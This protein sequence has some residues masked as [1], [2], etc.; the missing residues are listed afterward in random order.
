MTAPKLLPILAAVTVTLGGCSLLQ[1]E[2]PAERNAALRLE[3][4]LAALEAGAYREAFDELAWVYTHCP[5]RRAGVHALAALA[6]LELD[7]RNRA[8]RPEIGSELLA[9]VIRDPGTPT[10][11]RPLAESGYLMAAALG[12]PPA[13]G[14][15]SGDGT[16]RNSGG[17]PEAG[18]DQNGT[19]AGHSA[20]TRDRR[21]AQQVVGHRVTEPAY[22]CGPSVEAESWVPPPLPQLPGPSLLSILMDVEDQRDALWLRADTLSK[23]LAATRAQLE[24]T[25][26]ELERIRKT[27]KP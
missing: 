2:P 11:V 1:Q 7:P 19:H 24:E 20:R 12:A 17:D 26:A 21:S 16:A 15:V 25:R 23:E 9:R 22:G 27:L 13:P 4:G 14:T 5:A 18:T 10:W 3:I 8:G 6:A